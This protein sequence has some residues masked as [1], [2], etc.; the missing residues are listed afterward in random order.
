LDAA[1]ITALC[2]IKR[3]GDIIGFQ[4]YG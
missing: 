4:S 3:Q 2:P 1:D